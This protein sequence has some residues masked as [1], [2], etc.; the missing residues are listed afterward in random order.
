MEGLKSV[1]ALPAAAVH[2]R[3]YLLVV[4]YSTVVE[5]P[6]VS[7]RAKVWQQ[8]FALVTQPQV[9]FKL[10]L[11]ITVSR[12]NASDTVDMGRLY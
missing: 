6:T 9:K 5:H 2:Y 8:F 1:V 11:L 4:C 12:R 10:S 7:V 3:T